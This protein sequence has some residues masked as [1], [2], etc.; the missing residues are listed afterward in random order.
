M[1][2]PDAGRSQEDDILLPLEE[3]QGVETLKLLALDR[4][5]KEKS[6]PRWF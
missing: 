4:G 2:L 1:R 5:L 6:S 3:A